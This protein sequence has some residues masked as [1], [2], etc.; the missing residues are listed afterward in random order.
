PAIFAIVGAHRAAFLAA[1]HHIAALVVAAIALLRVMR[2]GCTQ[3]NAG[4]GGDIAVTAVPDLVSDQ[5][6]D[7]AAEHRRR[8]VAR[9]VVAVGGSVFDR[10]AAAFTAGPRLREGFVDRLHVDHA[11]HVVEAVV[12]ISITMALRGGR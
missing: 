11:G 4:D 10:L 12:G 6:A 2:G 5:A 7:D 1:A 3:R 9:A 8:L